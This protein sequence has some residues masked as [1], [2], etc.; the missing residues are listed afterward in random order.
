M[1]EHY[2]LLLPVFAS[3]KTKTSSLVPNDFN[4]TVLQLLRQNCSATSEYDFI[5]TTII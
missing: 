5:L 3:Y 4:A 2:P 1:G